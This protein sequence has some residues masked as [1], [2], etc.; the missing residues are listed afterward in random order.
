[1]E[2]VLGA[3]R[4]NLV[5]LA[6]AWVVIAAVALASTPAAAQVKPPD[7]GSLLR[8]FGGSGS[9]LQPPPLTPEQA[10]PKAVPLPK[11]GG[12]KV[13]VR[14]FHIVATLFP[15][16]VLKGQ[17]KDY[18]GRELSFADL[19][20]AAMKISEFYRAHDLLARAYLPPQTI[21]NGVVEIK[22]LEGREGKVKIDP[23]SRTR[24][25]PKIATG[26]VAYRAPPGEPLRP[27]QVQEGVEIL[28]ELPGVAATASLAP[29]ATEGETDTILKV[30]DTPL[31]TGSVQFDNEG[32]RSVGS[33]RAIASAAINDWLGIGD[34]VSAL[35]MRSAD[36]MYEHLASTV[37]VGDSGLTLGLDGSGLTYNVEDEF[38]ALNQG[39]QAYTYGGT[40]SYPI[41]RSPT[42]SLSAI[43]SF[44]H[45]QLVDWSAGADIDDKIV[46]VGTGGLTMR[47]IDDWLG[48]GLTTYT[49]A[50]TAGRLNL[51]GNDADLQ[52]DH[53]TAHSNGLYAKF[54]GSIA[55]LQKIS[56]DTQIYGSFFG[57]VAQ[58]NLDS[59]EKFSL[60]GPAGVRAYPVNEANG[61]DG[62]LAS[63][64]LRH[65]PISRVRLAGFYDL[66]GI[67]QHQ[68]TW[69]GWQPVVGQPNA[70]F[71]QGVGFSVLVTPIAGAT[72]KATLAEALGHNPGRDTNGDDS[73]GKE[74]RPRFWLE[75]SY[76]F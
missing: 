7:S 68:R 69:T 12:G 13:F 62:F 35:F 17:L 28:N 75:A 70:Y 26:F 15:E 76:S 25:D 73:D 23:S 47:S 59:S 48:G 64:E 58:K 5:I 60:G 21:R 49:A 32:V 65:E 14:D 34:Q 33:R 50:A 4:C 66:G 37:P 41:L 42:L 18:V 30:M 31:V 61:D 38:S 8:S 6:I 2:A 74:Y 57:Q 53:L 55:R 56:D 71:L 1:M 29:G 52:T 43:G 63:L 22:V 3:A 40:A 54:I 24:L 20:A 46:D 10:P 27:N 9:N 51:A 67:V 39:G 16:S 11:K 19:E 45:K 44:D 72:I 36:S